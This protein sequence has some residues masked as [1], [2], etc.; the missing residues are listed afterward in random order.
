MYAGVSLNEIANSNI[1]YAIAALGGL[2]W[3]VARFR[4]GKAT[5]KTQ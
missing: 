3:I 2:D 1:F 4:D 5:A